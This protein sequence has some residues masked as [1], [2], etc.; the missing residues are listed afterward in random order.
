MFTD[1]FAFE[2]FGAG[3]GLVGGFEELAHAATGV[4]A[5]EGLGAGLLHFD[6]E[7]GGRVLEVDAG[8]AAV[9]VLAA[10]SA[11]TDEA[12]PEVF[13]GQF[14]GGHALEEFVSFFC[15]HAEFGH[16]FPGR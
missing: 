8:G 12:L 13:F 11:G 16:G 10:R 14:A 15:C 5:V 1:F 6:F 7:A 9:D 2:L 4:E 3:A